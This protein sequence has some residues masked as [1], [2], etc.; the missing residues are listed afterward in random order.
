MNAALFSCNN[1]LSMTYKYMPRTSLSYA[2]L[3]NVWLYSTSYFCTR[4]LRAR[5]DP[6]L[7]SYYKIENL[8]NLHLPGNSSPFSVVS[9]RFS[10]CFNRELRHPCHFPIHSI[11][12]RI[13][14]KFPS[15]APPPPPP[16]PPPPRI[17]LLLFLVLF[18]FLFLL[19]LLLFFLLSLLLT[20]LFPLRC[21]SHRVYSCLFICHS[22][23]PPFQTTDTSHHTWNSCIRWS[24]SPSFRES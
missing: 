2:I 14:V 4:W 19:F 23:T 18:L 11:E 3:I 9:D 7:L 21:P 5:W 8:K 6:M 17:L 22:Y 12:F 15:P 16:S 1:V 20:L 10:I 13:T 24:R